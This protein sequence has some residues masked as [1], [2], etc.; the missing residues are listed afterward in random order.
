MRHCALGHAP[1]VVGG[2]A[3]AACG[4]SWP[5]RSLQSAAYETSNVSGKRSS[6]ICLYTHLLFSFL[7]SYFLLCFGIIIIF[8]NL[9]LGVCELW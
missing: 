1:D 5:D 3:T 9:I 4:K 2:A 8:F 7:T 6:Y